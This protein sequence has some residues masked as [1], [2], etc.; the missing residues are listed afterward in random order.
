MAVL[1]MRI[2]GEDIETFSYEQA[3]GGSLLSWVHIAVAAMV[4]VFLLCH[5]W[6]KA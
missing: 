2:L 3:L 6:K 4:S 5:Y 1:E